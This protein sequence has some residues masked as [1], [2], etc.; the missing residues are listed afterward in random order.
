MKTPILLTIL[1]A[2]FIAPLCFADMHEFTSADGEK[3][4]WAEVTG[5]DAAAK[6]VNLLL[7]NKSRITSPVTAFTEEDQKYI[8]KAAIALEAG[9]NLAIRFADDEEE[10]SEKRNPT[11]GYRTVELK[12]G[13]E[14]EL[15]N[16]GQE[17]FKGL[18]ADYQIF[19]AAYLN[20]FE[21]KARTDQASKGSVKLPELAPREETTVNTDGVGMTRITRLPLA[22]CSGGT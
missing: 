8:E 21:D 3:T 6:T 5:Y 20:P 16:N 1:A 18:T 10:L 19:Y 15:R 4:V 11:N 17:T 22:Q 14:L 9:R 13:F 2:C 7:T 12:S